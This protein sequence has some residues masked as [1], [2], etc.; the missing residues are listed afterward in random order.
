METNETCPD[1]KY[2]SNDSKKP[3]IVCLN[4]V[5]NAINEMNTDKRMIKCQLILHIH[6]LYSVSQ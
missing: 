4:R 5:L 6:K 2:N 1:V 3:E